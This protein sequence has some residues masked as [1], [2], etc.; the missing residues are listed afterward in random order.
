MREIQA[1]ISTNKNILTFPHL[2]NK[3]EILFCLE[4]ELEVTCGKHKSILKANDSV[5]VMPYTVH[6]YQSAKNS[7]VLVITV[8]KENLPLFHK[9]FTVEPTYP[10]IFNIT[11]N[12]VE[13]ITKK[14]SSPE[15]NHITFE[16]LIEMSSDNPCI[17]NLLSNI[18]VLVD[19][20]F[21]MNLKSM[22]LYYMGSRNQ[23]VID[24]KKSLKNKEVVLIE[25]YNNVKNYGNLRI[26]KEYIFI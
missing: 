10:F 5:L 22:D 11:D 14:L 13:N 24:V 3:L 15:S 21:D 8:L 17:M 19:G 6:S 16:K 26:E 20:K 23:R 7:K 25:K 18:D 1:E 9:Y 4:G 12:D 2:H